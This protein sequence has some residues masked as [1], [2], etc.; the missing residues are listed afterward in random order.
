MQEY[1]KRNFK[2]LL[3]CSVAKNS[4]N[5]FRGSTSLPFFTTWSFTF[6]PF[7]RMGICWECFPHH[8]I[9]I[10][11]ACKYKKHIRSLLFYS[12][13]NKYF[14]SILTPNTFKIFS[15]S[16]FAT[17]IYFIMVLKRNANE[18]NQLIGF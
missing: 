9:F 17:L 11:H 15:A 13:L 12:F 5:T 4:K 16:C 6:F 8:Q 2:S 14:L 1:V 3:Q 10:L 18:I 7:K